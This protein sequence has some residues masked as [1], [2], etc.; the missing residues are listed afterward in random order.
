MPKYVTR[1]R[2]NLDSLSAPLRARLKAD[3]S[4]FKCGINYCTL[5]KELG[6][7]VW[8]RE[9]N[10]PV[11]AEGKCTKPFTLISRYTSWDSAKKEVA[12]AW[13]IKVDGCEIWN[14]PN[15]QQMFPE[16]DRSN[17]NIA[18][19]SRTVTS[20]NNSVSQPPQTKDTTI[21]S[22][23]NF[24]VQE[25]EAGIQERIANPWKIDQGSTS[26]CG[27]A[28]VAYFYA[29]KKPSDYAQ[30][31][32]NLHKYGK[33]TSAAGYV[34]QTDSD[35][36]LQEYSTSSKAYPNASSSGKVHPVDFM[37][38]ASLRDNENGILDYDP[39]GDNGGSLGEGSSGFSLP[40]EVAKLMKKL[41]GLTGIENNTNLVFSRT[42]FLAATKYLKDLESKLI[43]GESIALLINM[44][45]IYG[46]KSYPS[47]PEHWIGLNAI[48]IDE[49]KQ[50]VTMNI[51]T[52]GQYGHNKY[53][54]IA[55]SFDVFID[56]VY[57]YVSG[58]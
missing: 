42:N 4:A 24:T 36:H 58:K 47:K 50:T 23:R 54:Q 31:V 35:R 27:M 34:L 45:L 26:L 13:N 43:S 9:D 22:F 30:F 11:N 7:P 49:K 14:I 3:P 20:C 32:R 56:N 37:L 1:L 39:D 51:F 41:A 44:G 57:G 55:I 33:A 52:W 46:E 29:K 38:L 6:N 48:N 19:I 15:V 2:I 25:V 53:K 40:F 16:N 12:A 5:D 18:N 10:L 8:K 21:P 17:W 28:V